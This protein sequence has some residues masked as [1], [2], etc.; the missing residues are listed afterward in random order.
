MESMVEWLPNKVKCKYEG[1]SFKRSDVVVVK[2]HE[3]KCDNRHVPCASCDDK[4]I[5][6]KTL[7]DHVTKK[8]CTSKEL[9]NGKPIE[10]KFGSPKLIPI[11]ALIESGCTKSQLVFV[12]TGDQE[13][14]GLPPETFLL[15]WCPYDD[16]FTLFW[17]AYVGPKE[18]ASWFDYTIQVCKNKE[19][20]GGSRVLLWSTRPCVPCDWSHE[21]MKEKRC[22]IMIEKGLLTDMSN[23]FITIFK[24]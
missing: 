19:Q 21:Y 14:A 15:N 23:F 6:L 1:C 18:S 3:E 10:I 22:A 4:K 24:P 8:H 13:N 2:K 16:F 12:V 7:A 11:Y 9:G 5:G 20:S 17:I